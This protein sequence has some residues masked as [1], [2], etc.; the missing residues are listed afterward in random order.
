MKRIIGVGL[1]LLLLAIVVLFA[2]IDPL[3]KA[4]VERGASH[5]TGVSTRV[6]SLDLTLL[7][8]QLDMRDLVVAN[9]A[10]E[11]QSPYFF[12]LNSLVLAV[13]PTS[14]LQSTV[15][16][17]RFIID[18]AQLNLEHAGGKTNFGTILDHIKQLGGTGT[19]KPAPKTE[20]GKR[21]IIGELEL[22]GISAQIALT[23]QLGERGQARAT[24]PTIRMR[25]VGAKSGGITLQQLSA[26]I[27]QKLLDGVK[28]SGILPA[29]LQQQ[30]TRSLEQVRTLRGTIQ[31]QTERAKEKVEERAKGAAEQEEKKLLEKGKELLPGR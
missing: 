14:L 11:Y 8:G 12:Q 24:L 16:I 2:S 26:L 17:P 29:Q 15:R 22:K 20:K 4:A 5:A 19:A 18:G 13:K 1:A 21:F 3:V 31:E 6:Q 23:R 30:L 27:V 7:G 28:N 9:P 25:D 10:G